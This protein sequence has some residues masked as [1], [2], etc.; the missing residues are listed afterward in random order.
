M[1][2]RLILYVRV[3]VADA[4]RNYSAR[5][6]LDAQ[7]LQ[8]LQRSAAVTRASTSGVLIEPPGQWREALGPN[9]VN[10]PARFRL[11]NDQPRSFQQLQMLHDRRA[12][13][14]QL[15]RELAR[16]ARSA[17]DALKNDHA[18]RMSEQREQTQHLAQLRRFC[19]RSSHA[20]SV[21][22]H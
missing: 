15:L 13:N 18:D 22:P 3:V 9:P 6:R 1:T 12:R 10:A 11:C 20:R 5:G 14:R 4:S 19:V 17:S 16:R 8:R 2:L 21:R 7:D